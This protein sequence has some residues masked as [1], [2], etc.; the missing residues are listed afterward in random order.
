[1]WPVEGRQR[2]IIEA[3]TPEID[4]GRYAIKRTVGEYVVVE[5]D[6]FADGHAQLSA[7]LCFREAGAEDWQEIFLEPIGNDRWRAQFQVTQ[8]GQAFYRILAWVDPFK[9]WQQDLHKRVEAQQDV[10]VELRIGA[11]LIERAA[12]RQCGNHGSGAE[13]FLQAKLRNYAQTLRQGGDAAIETALSPTLGSLMQVYGERPF[14]STYPERRVWVDPVK[15]RFSTWYELFPRSCGPDE[16]T[17]GT[18]RDVVARLPLIAEMGFDVLYL[19]PIHPIGRTF[20]KGKNNAMTAEP[21][22]VGSPWAIGGP[23]G[24]H[25]AIHPQLGSLADFH[26]LVAE[27]KRFHIDIALDIAFQ[28]SPDHPYVKEHP[29]WF[30]K[31]PDGSIQYAENPPKKYQDIYPLNFETE[32]WQALWE[33]LKSVIEYWIEQGVKIF[34]VD[35]P[36][37]K[38]FGFW[39]WCIGQIKAKHPETIFLSEA[40]TRPKLMKSLAKLGFTQSYTYF[41]WRNDKWGL[42]EYFTELTQSSMREYYRP[43]LWPNTPDILNEFLQ[44]GGR[45]AFMLRLILA[46][47]LGASYGIYGP[48]FELCE[49]RPLRPG[50]EEYLDSEKYQLRHWDLDAPDNLRPLIQQVNRIRRQ[51]PALQSDWSLVFHPTDNETLICYSKRTFSGDNRILV[52]VNLDPF[53]IQS[54]WVTLNLG[55]LDL[56]HWQTFKLTDLLDGQ[57]YSWQGSTNYIKLDPWTMPAHIFLLES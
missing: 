8:I 21:E 46:A 22:D 16:H 17:H 30:K 11:E 27:A 23:E 28:C 15:A 9:T 56:E 31:R 32:N 10:S 38:A 2:V 42:T 24:G 13:P 14:V 34:R 26:H 1:M 12:Q 51:N 49:N 36:H 39:E 29:E 53:H 7:V 5:A 57:Q 40:F 43:N 45:P 47:T 20:R 18:F 48:A 35:N 50:S 37:T 44:K 19:P 41:T 25:K 52:A 55:A 6:I 33:E 4:G 3:V 54:G